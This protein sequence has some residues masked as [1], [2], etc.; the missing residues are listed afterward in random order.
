MLKRKT[1]IKRFYCNVC[2]TEF[3]NHSRKYINYSKNYTV[4]E[5]CN[6]MS[7][8]LSMFPNAEWFGIDFYIQH[9]LKTNLHN[10]RS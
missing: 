3:I 10:R 8:L 6:R 1:K 2:E 4:C 5:S 7:S 9:F